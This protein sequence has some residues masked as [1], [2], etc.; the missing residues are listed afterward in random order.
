MDSSPVSWGEDGALGKGTL[1]RTVPL[2]MGGFCEPG[3]AEKV[4]VLE[5]QNPSTSIAN[6]IPCC[7]SY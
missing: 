7:A 4:T 6:L 1:E 5:K 2:R 3:I